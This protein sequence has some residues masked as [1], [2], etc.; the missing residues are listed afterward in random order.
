M[1]RKMLQRRPEW[2]DALNTEY[3][4]TA[5]TGVFKSARE[6]ARRED[7][8]TGYFVPNSHLG[9]GK[10]LVIRTNAEGRE[11]GLFLSYMLQEIF[12]LRQTGGIDF[13][14]VNIVDEAQDIFQGSPGVR[15]SA[16][17]RLNE[18]I[19]KGRSKDI[20]FVI[21]VQSVSQVPDSVLTNMNTRIIHRQ[22]SVEELRLA[23]PSASRDLMASSLTFGPGEALVSMI[24]ARSV[25]QAE[26][27][28]SPFELTKTSATERKTLGDQDEEA[29]HRGAAPALAAPNGRTKAMEPSDDEIPF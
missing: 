22:N 5:A 28:P 11:Y 10:I 17:A 1:Q 18:V 20:G 25:V 29:E 8:P 6:A 3:D 23:I 9:A 27:A 7:R 14:V 13:P 12:K 21:S 26:L 2:L 4:R 19:R 24:G 15:E 16:T